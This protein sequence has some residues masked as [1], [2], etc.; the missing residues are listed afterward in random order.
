[1]LIE[2]DDVAVPFSRHMRSVI[3]QRAKQAPD[4]RALGTR[5][6]VYKEGYEW[7]NHSMFPVPIEQ[8]NTRVMIGGPACT[9]PYSA[10]LLNISA[11]SY[12]ALSGNAISALNLGAKEGGFY[13][14]TGEGGIS[15][16]HLLGAD[17]VW[18][19][20]TGYFAC[21]TTGADGI[22]RFDPEMFKK[23][24]SRPEIKMIELKLSQGAKPAHG[25]ILPK[26][27]ITPIIAEAR[28]L[29]PPPWEDCVSPPC[30]NAFTSPQ[31]MLL[32]VQKLREMSGGKPVGIKLCVGQ[33]HEVAALV[34]AM[35]DTGV[36]PDFM[37]IDGA[38]G[39]TGAAPA[40]FQDSVGMPLAEGLRLVNSY[41]IGANLRSR[42]KLI[43][44]GK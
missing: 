29:G 9:Q 43:A 20:G 12:G 16:F 6:D 44:S 25:G 7:V 42:I 15:K 37:T 17:V 34:H 39:G 30:H 36:T 13:H 4:T 38:E 1:Y 22:R 40:E 18:N 19:V 41:L 2:S 26:S 23:N 3:Y 10:S 33:P 24:A 21:G 5:M 27:K 32:F 14:N 28:G 8:I 31:G 11:M 35:L